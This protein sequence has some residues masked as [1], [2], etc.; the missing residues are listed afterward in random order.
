MAFDRSP[1]EL[2]GHE[3]SLEVGD[4]FTLLEM[5]IPGRTELHSRVWWARDS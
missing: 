2:D 1:G 5:H 3:G 4:R